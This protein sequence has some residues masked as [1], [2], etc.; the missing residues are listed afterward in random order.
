[1]R[2][3]CA[4]KNKW[5]EFLIII[6]I[7]IIIILSSSSIFHSDRVSSTKSRGVGVLTAISSRV[8]TC[9]HRYDIQFYDECVWVEIFTQSG[10]SYLLLIIIP[11]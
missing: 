2:N 3:Q 11:P 10:R 1:M 9:K 4:K 5:T 6:I 8:P 7:I